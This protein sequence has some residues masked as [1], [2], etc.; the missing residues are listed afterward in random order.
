[1]A[2]TVQARPGVAGMNGLVGH[3]VAT[4]NSARDGVV[5]NAAKAVAVSVKDT[6]VSV[7][8]GIILSITSTGIQLSLSKDAVTEAES[9][10]S[11]AEDAATVVGDILDLALAAVPGGS[12]IASGIA[13]L[14]AD[15]IGLGSDLLSFCTDSSGG[16]TFSIPWPWLW[17]SLDLP[18][19]NGISL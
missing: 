2:A 6:T 5:V 7:L 13:E 10:A 18:S 19:C 8:P 15:A 1:M 12:E 16:A 3:G 9:V 11:F 17:L 4:V 14:A